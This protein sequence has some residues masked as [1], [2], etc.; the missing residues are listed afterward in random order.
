MDI[1]S[2]SAKYGIKLFMVNDAASQYCI[3][4]IPYLGRGSTP[5][6][7]DGY[8]QGE[9]FTMKVIQDSGLLAEG[10][11]V[12]MDNWFTSLHLVETLRIHNMHAVGTIRMNKTQLP[13]KAFIK[14]LKLPK[15]ETVAFHNHQRQ[16]ILAV[17]KVK[18]EKYV[19]VIS[20]IHNKLTVVEGRKT[21]AHMFYNASKGG[22]DV[23]DMMCA[24]TDIGRKTVCWPMY[25]F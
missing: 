2:K 6:L 5:A 3:N 20:T 21:E 9:Y 15:G 13:P 10:R 25:T 12:V 22:V 11:V 14:S 7:R 1:P 24:Q 18:A 8:N 16:M 17:K 19:G 23:F 4:A